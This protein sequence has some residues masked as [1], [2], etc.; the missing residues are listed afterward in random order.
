MVTM[1]TFF[2]EVYA[3]VL[4][5]CKE[6]PAIV[7]AQLHRPG[8]WPKLDL[9]AVMSLSICAQWARFRS[10]RDFYRYA[11]QALAGCCAE[12]HI[13][14]PDRSQYNRQARRYHGQLAEL[15]IWVAERL[16]ARHIELQVI[17]TTP[18]VVRDSRRRGC[19]WLTGD[20]DIGHCTRLGWFQGFRLLVAAGAYGAITGY[21]I[22]PASTNERRMAEMLL[23][24]RRY[25]STRTPSVG[26]PAMGNYVADK[27]FAGRR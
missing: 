14:L 3:I 24:L 9:P 10:E 2:T 20:S 7:Q 27:G 17:D 22:A 16:Q 13:Q 21:C 6:H 23:M 25:R 5:F 15:V 26:L 11:Q 18:I 4:D 19:R 12:H 1:S 8:P